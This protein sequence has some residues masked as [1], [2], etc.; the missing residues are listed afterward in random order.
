MD[1]VHKHGGK[2]ERVYLPAIGITDNTHFPFADL[3]NTQFADYL[4]H[5][6]HE[7]ALD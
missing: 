4:T 2:A 7:K 1:V 6:L 3:R 5:W